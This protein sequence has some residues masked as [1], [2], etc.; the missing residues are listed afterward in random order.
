LFYSRGVT[1][2]RRISSAREVERLT[3]SNHVARANVRSGSFSIALDA[4]FAHR[5]RLKRSW[6]SEV[7]KS[8]VQVSLVLKRVPSPDASTAGQP[9][10]AR[11]T[12]ALMQT[13]ICRVFTPPHH[14]FTGLIFK[15]ATT[16]PR[17]WLAKKFSPVVL[18]T[19]MSGS[20]L[21][22]GPIL[23]T[24]NLVPRDAQNLDHVSQMPPSL[25]SG[26]PAPSSHIQFAKNGF[27]PR[28]MRSGID[29]LNSSRSSRWRAMTTSRPIYEAV[30]FCSCANRARTA[31]AITIS[32]TTRK[33]TLDICH[34][35]ATVFVTGSFVV[36]RVI[37][38]N[39]KRE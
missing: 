4:S 24:D 14:G 6:V 31:V 9:I 35:F 36:H 5:H 25:V 16:F 3:F 11:I 28:A 8:S 32:A 34:S 38:A 30:V 27:V 15:G 2:A 23:I 1:S 13:A 26:P 18:D 21:A 39:L 7:L 17:R 19:Y 22:S 12:S 10:A 29:S 33:G 20:S 37:S